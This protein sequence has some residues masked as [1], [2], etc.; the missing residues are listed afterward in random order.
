[1]Q[2]DNIVPDQEFQRLPV[3]WA[4]NELQAALLGGLRFP[5]DRY[6]IRGHGFNYFAVFRSL[7]RKG[8]EV[9]DRVQHVA[10]GLPVRAVARYE[11]SAALSAGTAK[12]PLKKAACDTRLTGV[13]RMNSV[14][15]YRAF[16]REIL[17]ISRTGV[18]SLNLHRLRL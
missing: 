17:D 6:E 4:S 14:Q 7:D 18:Q 1:M 9:F 5:K 11:K 3:P 10:G 13:E 8:Q 16:V 15:T 2:T 12:N